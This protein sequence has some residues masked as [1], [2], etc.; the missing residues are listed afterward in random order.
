MSM[1]SAW[2]LVE[3]RQRLTSVTPKDWDD[4]HVAMYDY[5]V[6]DQAKEILKDF[7]EVFIKM[8]GKPIRP[9]LWS[10]LD[11]HLRHLTYRFEHEMNGRVSRQVREEGIRYVMFV[12]PGVQ[13][14]A[15]T[16]FI[17]FSSSERSLNGDCT[18][19]GVMR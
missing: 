2:K 15:V 10:E 5:E 3:L 19:Q 14:W 1:S 17:W 11:S 7:Q 8:E 4:I 13:D 6:C 18:I 16:I 12:L 9:Q